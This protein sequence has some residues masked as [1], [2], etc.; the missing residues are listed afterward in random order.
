MTPECKDAFKYV[1]TLGDQLGMEVA[2]A[3][4]SRME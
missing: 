2:I 4:F 1:I 3:G